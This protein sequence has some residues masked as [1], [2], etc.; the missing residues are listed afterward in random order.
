MTVPCWPTRASSSKWRRGAP[1][2]SSATADS[3]QYPIVPA[4]R[5]PA[6]C[7]GVGREAG[8]GVHISHHKAAGEANFGKVVDS[9]ALV[10]RA[11]AE[12]ADVT[13]DVYPYT[14]GSGRMI[15]YFNIDEPDENLARVIR[16]A[17]CP[18]FP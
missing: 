15:E 4:T 9:L 14:A 8:C 16:L 6:V 1:A 3:A 5:P 2:W 17:S 13:L 7:S 11:N 18:A 10:D 12:G